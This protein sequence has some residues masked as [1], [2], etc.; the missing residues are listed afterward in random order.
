MGYFNR[1]PDVYYD[2]IVG[3]ETEF[4][5]VIQGIPIKGFMDRVDRIGDDI[6]IIDYKTN[7]RLYTREDIAIDLQASLYTIAAR[8]LW[9]DAKKIIFH[10]EMLRFG[11][12]Q[13]VERTDEQLRLAENYVVDLT[14]A[15]ERPGRSWPAKTGPLCAY[16]DHFYECETVQN[17][18]ANGTEVVAV[19]L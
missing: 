12:R 15:S 9:P 5:I 17:A 8:Q 6:H 7:S 10:F 3:V 16:C 19:D 1:Y 4:N 11:I 13:T 14:R 2:E 18:I